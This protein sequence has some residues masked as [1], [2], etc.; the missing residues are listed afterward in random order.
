MTDD[1]IREW[2]DAVEKFRIE[3]PEEYAAI[4]AR[5]EIAWAACRYD[6]STPNTTCNKCGFS[7]YGKS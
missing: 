5:N 4:V 6:H 3:H 1:Q 7:N 2:A